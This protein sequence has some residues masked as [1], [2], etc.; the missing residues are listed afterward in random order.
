MAGLAGD[1]HARADLRQ[2]LPDD[3]YTLTIKDD[4]V[5]PAG[6]KLDGESNARSPT[7][8]RPSPAA[9]A[10]PGGNFVARFTVDSRPEIG[11]WSGGSVYVDTNGNFTFDPTN[12]DAT[13]RDLTYTLGLH[14]R[15]AFRRQLRAP[16]IDEAATPT[17]F[18]K[19]AAYGRVGNGSIAG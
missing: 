5:D 10:Q 7:A 9:T 11:T 18:D 8:R 3:R 2:P 13:N 12:M 16:Y 6:N 4:V 19:L 17:A 1:R 15:Q 14:Q